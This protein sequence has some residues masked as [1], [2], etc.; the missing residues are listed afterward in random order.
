MLHVDNI[1]FFLSIILIEINS[2]HE[3]V[4]SPFPSL[5]LY[6]HVAGDYKFK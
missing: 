1:A 3:F 6:N 5:V 4:P 2:L